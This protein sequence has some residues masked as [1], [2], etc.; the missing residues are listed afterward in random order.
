MKTIAL[1]ITAVALTASL[2][3]SVEACPNVNMSWSKTVHF[4]QGA[5]YVRLIVT[6]GTGYCAGPWIYPYNLST[7]ISPGLWHVTIPRTSSVQT[8]GFGYISNYG[9]IG[10]TVVFL[11]SNQQPLSGRRWGNAVPISWETVGGWMLSYRNI[12]ARQVVNNVAYAVLDHTVSQ[13]EL[14]DG[15]PMLGNMEPVPGG[16]D[17]YL[18]PGMELDLGVP[19]MLLPGQNLVVRQEVTAFSDDGAVETFVDYMQMVSPLPGDVDNNGTVDD[20]DLAIVLELFGQ[21]DDYGDLDGDG[22]V[23]DIDLAIVLENFGRSR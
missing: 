10:V 2:A 19:T 20:L 11:D 1:G 6:H 3:T 13:D 21:I 16:M 17:L 12:T 8:V 18:E 9:N 23:T 22:V 14:R 7:W 15:N 5:A 4:P